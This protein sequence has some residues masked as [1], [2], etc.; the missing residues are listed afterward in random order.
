MEF[1]CILHYHCRIE[2][3]KMQTESG[4]LHVEII[5]VHFCLPSPL[6]IRNLKFKTA[7]DINQTKFMKP[8]PRLKRQ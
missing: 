3:I 7:I 1:N 5:D 8:C 6:F 4:S 2:R